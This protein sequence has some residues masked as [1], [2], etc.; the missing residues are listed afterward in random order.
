MTRLIL[1]AVLAVSA[2]GVD[3]PPERPAERPVEKRFQ[4]QARVTISG[5][6]VVG[7]AANL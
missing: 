5:D 4:Q 7:V 3:G 6:A 2:C 1:A